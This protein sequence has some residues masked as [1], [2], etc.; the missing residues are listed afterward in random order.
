MRVSELLDRCKAVHLPRKAPNTKKTYGDSLAAFRSY[1]V[2]Q[3][4]DPLA[5]NVRPGHVQGYLHWRRNH[6]PDG[7]KLGRSL[8]ARTVAKD[9][10]VLHAVFAFGEELEVVQGNP[11]RTVKPPKGDVREPL[12]LTDDQ[13]EDLLT[14]CEHRPELWLFVLLL[15]E[16]GLRCESEALWIEWR[17][18]DFDS[19]FLTVESRPGEHRTKSG[20]SR[21]VPMTPRLQV[22]LR[23]H[24]DACQEDSPWVFHHPMTRRTKRAGERIQSMRGAYENAVTRAKL[25]KQLHQHDLRHRR[26][27]TWLAAGKSPVLV[28]KAM[29]HADIQ[30]TMRY[31]HLV[32][33]D[34]LALIREPAPA[35]AQRKVALA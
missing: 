4:G 3:E 29:G 15:G 14:A 9:R 23:K 32:A 22:A 33:E 35:P 20:K 12:I 19:G 1:F 34:L 26:V 5:H 13:Y 30:T 25:P 11:V 16:T 6:A 8:A 7:T 2:D 10:A 24:M 28:Q 21:K 31:T 27:T 17:H 18:I